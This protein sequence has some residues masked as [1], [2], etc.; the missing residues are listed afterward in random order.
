[1]T[2][3]IKR[4]QSSGVRNRGD[5]DTKVQVRVGTLTVEIFM[6][7]SPGSACRGGDLDNSFMTMQTLEITLECLININPKKVDAESW[8]IRSGFL[9]IGPKKVDIPELF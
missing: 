9:N 5:S 2:F 6:S 1:M 4:F 8:M 3:K 7:E